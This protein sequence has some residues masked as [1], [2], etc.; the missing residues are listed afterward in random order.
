MAVIAIS[1]DKNMTQE[2]LK[3]YLKRRGIGEFAAYMDARDHIQYRIKMRGLPTTYLLNP[4]GEVM[5]VFEGDA[6][7]FSPHAIDFF[8]SL[9]SQDKG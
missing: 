2:Q 8:E 4:K 1:L 3:S 9:L 6:N 7:W 5:H